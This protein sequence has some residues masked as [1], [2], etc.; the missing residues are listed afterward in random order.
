MWS[1]VLKLKLSNVTSVI[2]FL[3]RY[4]GT[5]KR[6]S[7]LSK[8]LRSVQC[9]EQNGS[10]KIDYQGKLVSLVINICHQ[11]LLKEEQS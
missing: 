7:S 8:L 1:F 4:C 9:R 3:L 6:S 11:I 5:N 10:Q 2:P